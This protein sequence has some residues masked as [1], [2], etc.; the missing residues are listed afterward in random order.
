VEGGVEHVAFESP[1]LG[2]VETGW[3]KGLTVAGRPIELHDY[4][5]FDNPYCRVPFGSR[6]ALLDFGDRG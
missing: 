1:T 5:R 6:E 4:P 3:G 2:R